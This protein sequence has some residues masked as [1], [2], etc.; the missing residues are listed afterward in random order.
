MYKCRY[1]IIHVVCDAAQ[2]WSLLLIAGVVREGEFT[3]LH[4]CCRCRR[5]TSRALAVTSGYCRCSSGWFYINRRRQL[6]PRMILYSL[7]ACEASRTNEVKTFVC[8][9][10]LN[11]IKS[12]IRLI[13]LN[14]K[15]V[16]I[17]LCKILKI[18]KVSKVKKTLNSYTKI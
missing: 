3:A 2:G 15:V 16:P 4:R 17:T 1:L 10:S 9:P 8:L 5:Y 13:Q 11:K 18:S 6:L 14:T 7:V 12:K